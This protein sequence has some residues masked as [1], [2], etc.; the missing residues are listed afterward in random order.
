MVVHD[1]EAAAIRTAYEK[2]LA[3]ETLLSICR[4]LEAQGFMSAPDRK[5]GGKPFNITTL[6]KTLLLASR[7]GLMV[8]DGQ[9]IGPA[10]WPAIID[11]ATW[12]NARAILTDPGRKTSPGPETAWLLT[13][14]DSALT[15]GV[16]GGTYFRVR[17]GTARSRTG[18]AC[19]DGHVSRD[20]ER[21]DALVTAA[22]VEILSRPEAARALRP[23]TDVTA[24]NARRTAIRTQLNAMAADGRLDLEQVAIRSVPLREELEAID[25]RLTTSLDGSALDGI[26]GQQDAE[27][28]WWS[29]TLQRRRAIVKA[30]VKVTILPTRS[31]K[32]HAIGATWF[33]PESVRIEPR[34]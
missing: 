24:L 27:A 28:T 8:H 15:C 22:V 4:W 10:P 14:R 7:A 20:S 32:G 34:W 5:N 9:I 18:Y 1:A 26:A 30:T 25:A 21:T 3:G 23:D 16:C 31:G 11:R 29:H 13:G 33:D 19:W 6:R 12:E 17:K 2:V